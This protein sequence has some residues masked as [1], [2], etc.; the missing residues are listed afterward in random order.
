MNFKI[1]NKKT[2]DFTVFWVIF[3]GVFILIS[4]YVCDNCVSF[5]ISL[6]LKSLNGQKIISLT[7]VVLTFGLNKRKARY[8]SR[9]GFFIG[10]LHISLM[11][12]LR[13][14]LHYY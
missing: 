6:L 10:I 9:S 13:L 7:L 1:N 11:L 4:G 8:I 2:S 3:Y 5:T 14:Q 12:P